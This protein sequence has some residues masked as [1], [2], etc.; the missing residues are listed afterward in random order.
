MK[1]LLLLI[2]MLVF[3]FQCSSGQ[4]RYPPRCEAERYYR[5]KCNSCHR[6]PDPMDKTAEQWS[7]V[8]WEHQKR[9]SLDDDNLRNMIAFMQR[10]GVCSDTSYAE[11]K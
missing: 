4:F 11:S 2:S 6:R 5:T 8:L 3:F 10:G 7:V 9:L 1:N